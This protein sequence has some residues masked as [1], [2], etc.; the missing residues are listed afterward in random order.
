[1]VALLNTEAGLQLNLMSPWLCCLTYIYSTTSFLLSF[2][3]PHF[4]LLLIVPHSL[5]SCLP[6]PPSLSSSFSL[7]LPPSLSSSYLSSSFSLCFFL[8][9]SS[10]LLLYLALCPALPLWER[11]GEVHKLTGSVSHVTTMTRNTCVCL[12]SGPVGVRVHGGA[13]LPRDVLHVGTHHASVS[14]HRTLGTQIGQ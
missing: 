7:S 14:T 4:C 10:L 9:L 6:V 12:W 1:M 8:S 13:D 2:S 5:S 11:G 3:Q